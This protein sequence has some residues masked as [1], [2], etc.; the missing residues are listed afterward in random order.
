MV[1]CNTV[2]NDSLWVLWVAYVWTWVSVFV[3]VKKNTDELD[4]EQGEK[5]LVR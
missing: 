3:L 4:M 1:N 2:P 5:A